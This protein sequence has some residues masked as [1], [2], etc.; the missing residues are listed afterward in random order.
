MAKI[1][2]QQLE[3]VMGTVRCAAHILM[4]FPDTPEDPVFHQISDLAAKLWSVDDELISIRKKFVKD[5][6]IE[7]KIATY[8]HRHSMDA[9]IGYRIR[10]GLSL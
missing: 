5:A 7:E 4:N 9:E 2:Q 1:Y 6:S 8:N 10:N 3:N